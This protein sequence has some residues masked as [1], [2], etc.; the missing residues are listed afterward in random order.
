MYG[1]RETT[2]VINQTAGMEKLLKSHLAST[3]TKIAEAVQDVIRLMAW[4]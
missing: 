3:E 1:D 4:V 2:A